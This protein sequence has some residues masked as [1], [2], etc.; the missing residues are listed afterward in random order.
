MSARAEQAVGELQEWRPGPLE[1]LRDEYLGFVAARGDSALERDGGPEHLTASCFVL[2]PALDRVLLCYHRKG[3]FWVQLGGHLEPDD[4]SLSAAALREAREESGVGDLRL[5]GSLPVD[6]DRHAL[7]SGFGRCSTHWD[8]G[9]AA[10]ADP[11]APLVVS[12]ESDDVA[13]W[14]VDTLPEEVPPEFAARLH[15][16]VAAAR[17]RR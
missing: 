16:A 14:P 4:A 8:V 1:R 7:S 13:W 2:S 10:I 17:E 5:L 9:Y 11:E 12:D 6:L 3:R 15:G